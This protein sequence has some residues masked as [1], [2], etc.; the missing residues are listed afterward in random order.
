[1]QKI[2][3]TGSIDMF[4]VSRLPIQQSQVTGLSSPVTYICE[5]EKELNPQHQSPSG[6]LLVVTCCPLLLIQ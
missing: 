5:T 3:R 6:P 2:L 1:M 4:L